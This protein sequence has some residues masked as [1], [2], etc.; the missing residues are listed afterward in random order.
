M[1]NI[2]VPQNVFKNSLT[3]SGRASSIEVMIFYFR[4]IYTQMQIVDYCHWNIQK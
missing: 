2:K 1:P 3:G 4:N